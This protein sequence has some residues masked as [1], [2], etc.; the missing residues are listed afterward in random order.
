MT[1]TVLMVF[2][3]H[4]PG[5]DIPAG[6]DIAVNGGCRTLATRAAHTAQVSELLLHRQVTG[7]KGIR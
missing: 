4:V 5:L 6:L 1:V 2:Q 3:R 7:R